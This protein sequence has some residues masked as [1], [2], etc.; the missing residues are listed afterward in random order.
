MFV[1]DRPKFFYLR[2]YFLVNNTDRLRFRIVIHCCLDVICKG[3]YSLQCADW[4]VN[5]R[6]GWSYVSIGM[7][8]VV[9]NWLWTP[10]IRVIR[11]C[12]KSSLCSAY[13]YI[14]SKRPH[15]NEHACYV[16]DV[17]ISKLTGQFSF[18]LAAICRPECCIVPPFHSILFLTSRIEIPWKKW[19]IKIYSGI[20]TF[21]KALSK[22]TL[23]WMWRSCYVMFY[24]C[25]HEQ[26]QK[27]IW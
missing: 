7:K 19:G 20:S 1:F 12:N 4:D 24:K 5:N 11:Y 21:H 9:W 10:V 22:D 14:W 25:L 8:L 15:S 6:W 13:T 26:V 3:S 27:K 2:S 23:A 18:C 16:W 17:I